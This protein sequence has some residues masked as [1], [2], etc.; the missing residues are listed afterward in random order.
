[1]ETGGVDPI[2][3][4]SVV[5]STY[6]RSDALEP[7]LMALARQDVQPVEYE[8][9]VVDDGST[10]ET[11][12]VLAAISVPYTLRTFRQPFNQGVSAGRNVGLRHAAGT[13][14]II[15][16]DDLLVPE[17]FISTHVRTLERFPDA[18]VVGGFRQL[19]ALTA[20]PFGRF[21][22]ALE[23]SF[24]QGRLGRRIDV[25]LYEMTWPTARNLSL[26]RSDLQRIG[27]FD[28]QF[29][30]TCEDQDLAQRARVQGIRFLYNAGLESFH[31]DQAS[32]LVRYCR[33]QQRGARD[34]VRLCQK[35]PE[36]HGGAP[37]AR[38]NGYVRRSDPPSVTARKLAKRALSVPAAT[39]AFEKAIG[40]GEHLRLPDRW[41][42]RAYR[43]IIGIYTFRGFRE[44]L[45]Q[46]QRDDSWRSAG[47]T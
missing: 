9:L 46:S 28:E 6:N 1:M 35:Y 13:Y 14:I 42:A 37:I 10:D 45:R 24:E 32:D 8:V 2:V 34:T 41:L 23:R 43:A 18:W 38:L 47:S 31:N 44:G 22:D 12:A 15:L 5:V 27:L 11:Q 40:F 29:R 21:V 25:D 4:A 33:F 7:T 3:L 20:T 19:E 16:S 36:I 26:R 39:A 17:N 30:V